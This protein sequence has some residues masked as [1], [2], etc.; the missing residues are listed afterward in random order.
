VR[1]GRFAEQLR[2]E[3]ERGYP[4]LEA[5]RAE[6]RQSPIEQVRRRLAATEED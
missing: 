2:T 1:A 6:A 5:A 3:E 4:L